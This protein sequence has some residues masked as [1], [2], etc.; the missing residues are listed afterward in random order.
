MTN[1]LTAY[2]GKI[3]EFLVLVGTIVTASAMA[4]GLNP[5]QAAFITML[6]AI[7]KAAE[8]TFV[9]TPQRAAAL[10]AFHNGGAK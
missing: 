8:S 4:L 10:I 7:L 1:F 5:F 6:V 9:S 2:G 3:L